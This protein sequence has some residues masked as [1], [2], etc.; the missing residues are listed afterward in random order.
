MLEGDNLSSLVLQALS[1]LIEHLKED[2]VCS[3]RSFI[4]EFFYGIYILSFINDLISRNF[5]NCSSSRENGKVYC[6]SHVFLLHILSFKCT[7]K[8]FV[9]FFNL[10][11]IC[12]GFIIVSPFAMY[13]SKVTYTCCC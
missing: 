13:T 6:L 3:L 9:S 10:L 2:K 12:L 5:I 7:L 1:L 11:T 4:M 8:N